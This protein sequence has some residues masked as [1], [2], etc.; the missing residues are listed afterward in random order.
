MHIKMGVLYHNEHEVV[1]QCLVCHE[2]RY[3]LGR[4]RVPKK[5]LRHFPLI[6]RLKQMFRALNLSK[7][8]KWH[9]D[10]ISKDEY[11]K[12]VV[13]SKAWARINFIWLEFA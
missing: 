13:D 7:F 2:C 11:V 5:V 6:L 4:N 8:M 10:N 1:N 3:V 9:H 12:H